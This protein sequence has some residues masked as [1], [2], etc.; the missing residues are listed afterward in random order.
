MAMDI[1]QIELNRI[2]NMI[3]GRGFT[4]TSSSMADKRIQ[5]K[6]EKVI[7][8]EMGVTKELE[9]TWITNFLK[10]FSWK[11]TETTMGTDKIIVTFEKVFPT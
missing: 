9:A 10:G 4:I 8:P 3:K 2:V 11:V 1:K 7:T 6:T 5:V